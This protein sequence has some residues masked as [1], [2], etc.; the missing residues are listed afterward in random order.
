MKKIYTSILLTFLAALF[1][2]AC[3]SSITIKKRHYRKGYYIN[4]N[5]EWNN[6]SCNEAE[7]EAQLITREKDAESMPAKISP[8]SEKSFPA[9]KN[10]QADE[11]SPQSK[12]HKTK[13]VISTYKTHY[14]LPGKML[15]K[16]IDALKKNQAVKKINA[17]KDINDDDGYSLLWIVI[18]ILLI[19]WLLGVLSGGWGL[20][21]LLYI[22]LV[23]ALVLLILWLLKIL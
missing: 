17:V 21:G 20:G 7:N 11:F 14:Q 5:R 2:S 10:S 6:A 15:A 8:G 4:I 23:I 22:L 1:F 13:K 16:K 3:N 9:L 18:L 19:L 12:E